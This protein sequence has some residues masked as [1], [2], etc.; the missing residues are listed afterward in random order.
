MDL[1][2]FM[3]RDEPAISLQYVMKRCALPDTEAQAG[4]AATA[5]VCDERAT[6]AGQGKNVAQDIQ[7]KTL[8]MDGGWV[9]GTIEHFL[10]NDKAGTVR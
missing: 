3:R 10:S 2:R 1:Q 6:D 7:G 8:K 4:L 9:F 5:D